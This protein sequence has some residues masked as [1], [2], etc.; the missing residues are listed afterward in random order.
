MALALLAVLLR[1]IVPAG[2]MPAAFVLGPD[3]TMP[4]VICAGG[5][6]KTVWIDADGK[7]V[8]VP[9]GAT[10]GHHHSPCV[11]CGFAVAVPEPIPVVVA[12]TVETVAPRAVP[13]RAPI[14]HAQTLGLLPDSRG[15]PVS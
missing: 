8:D 13:R 5:F 12:A 11:F 10:G 2:A 3:G 6:A 4:V 7:K 9:P 1:G 14:A 15:P